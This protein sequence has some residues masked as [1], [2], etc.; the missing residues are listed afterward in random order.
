MQCL[1]G[2]KGGHAKHLIRHRL[3]LRTRH[4]TST[5]TFPGAEPDALDV[6]AATTELRNGSDYQPVEFT[7]QGSTLLDL[8]SEDGFVQGL[9][10]NSANNFGGDDMEDVI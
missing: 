6:E 2:Q 5:D 3:R 10:A 1:A 9:Q 8:E 4:G 7:T